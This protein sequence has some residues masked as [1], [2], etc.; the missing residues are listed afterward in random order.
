M[1]CARRPTRIHEEPV[2]KD[3][4][5]RAALPVVVG[6]F[7]AEAESEGRQRH[8]PTGLNQAAQSI[9]DVPFVERLR[10]TE[11]RDRRMDYDD[12]GISS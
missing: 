6:T 4:H 12:A 5:F 10:W 7:A 9:D 2:G 1:R 11:V 3:P 8:R